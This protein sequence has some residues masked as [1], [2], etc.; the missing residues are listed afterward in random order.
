MKQGTAL[1]HLIAAL[2][3]VNISFS[4]AQNEPIPVDHSQ[5][6]SETGHTSGKK[7]VTTPAETAVDR[8]T[9]PGMDHSKMNHDAMPGMDHGNMHNMHDMQKMHDMHKQ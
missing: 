3:I 2:M 7:T 4:W 8:E 5:H 1:K 9:M 6:S